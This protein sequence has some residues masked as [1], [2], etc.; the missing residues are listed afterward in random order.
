MYEVQAYGKPNFSCF[1]WS[2][3][4]HVWILLAQATCQTSEKNYNFGDGF[5][6]LQSCMSEVHS[7]ENKLTKLCK[8]RLYTLNRGLKISYMCTCPTNRSQIGLK[9]KLSK[10]FFQALTPK[11]HSHCNPLSPDSHIIRYSIMV[12]YFQIW[13]FSVKSFKLFML[14]ND[15]CRFDFFSLTFC[16]GRYKFAKKDDKCPS[17]C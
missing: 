8:P 16:S 12:F 11:F 17:Q 15:C 2:S 4:K 14:L 13:R 7:E 9:A 3:N 1:F 10:L 5:S 6:Q